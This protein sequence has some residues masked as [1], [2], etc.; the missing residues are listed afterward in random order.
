MSITQR[1][2]LDDI[3]QTSQSSMVE[4]KE[5]SYEGALRKQLHF[6]LGIWSTLKVFTDSHRLS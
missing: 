1:L 4:V 2:N 3:K 5:Y 6:I